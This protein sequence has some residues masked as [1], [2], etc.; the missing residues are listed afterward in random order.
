[1]KNSDSEASRIGV[2]RLFTWDAETATAF[3]GGC[4]GMQH[5]VRWAV[6]LS[7][8]LVKRWTLPANAAMKTELK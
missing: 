7:E 1:M 8:D 4:Q 2:F 3:L 6:G 5:L